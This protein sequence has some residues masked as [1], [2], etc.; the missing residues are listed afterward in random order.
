VSVN[1]NQ[2]PFSSDRPIA[3][4]EEDL[5]GRANF[6]EALATAIKS[7]REKDSLVIA[8]YG[9]WG[10]GKTS[11]KNMV[12]DYL[13]GS[14]KDS[15]EIVEFNPWQWAGQ[16]QL[17]NAFFEEIGKVLGR[18]TTRKTKQIAKK[19]K[20]YG[21]G[22]HLT[23]YV[24]TGFRNALSGLLL[25][26]AVFGIGGATVHSVLSNWLVSAI[27]Y[28]ALVLAI[29]TKWGGGF[30]EKLTAFLDARSTAQE[31]GSAELKRELAVSLQVLDRPVL[32]VVD[33]VDRL[34]GDEIR[35]L[36]QLIK[37][38][39][40]FP[41]L[42]YLVLFQR[43]IVQAA[44][45]RLS[46]APGQDFLEK[47][48]QVGLDIPRIERTRLEQVL[49]SGLDRIL[50]QQ[51][52]S[53]KFD[54]VRWANVFFPGLRPYFQT[55]RDVFRFL[56]T[57][58]FHV[59]IF[60]KSGPL[61]VNPIDLI[62]VETLRVFEPAVYS[63]LHDA[64]GMLTSTA[65]R[66]ED[67]RVRKGLQDI[68]A[69]APEQ[70]RSQVKELLS[71]LFPTVE[72]VFGGSRYGADWMEGWYRDLRICHEDIF[73]KYFYLAIPIGDISQ[74]DIERLLATTGNRA[75]LVTAFRALKE[76]G[77]LGV[78]IDR[79]EAYKQTISLD[80]A[81]PFVTALFDIGD[82]LPEGSPGLTNLSPEMH[83]SRIVYWY[84]K[85]EKDAAKR[86]TILK[87]AM[88]ATTGLY[89][90]IVRTSR[91]TRYPEKKREEG[92]FLVSEDAAKELQAICLQKIEAAASSGTLARHPELASILYR[93]RDWA[94]VEKPRAWIQTLIQSD[95]GVLAFLTAFLQQ[96][97][98]QTIGDHA[99][100]THWRIRLSSLEPFAEIE[101]LEHRVNS[102][103]VRQ[104][105]E[106]QSEAINQF[107]KAI[108]RKKQGRPDDDWFHDEHED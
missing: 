33:D 28:G 67:E 69:A 91:E 9:P 97:T 81:V 23:A 104:L 98:S 55:L 72:W 22:L 61:E 32:V 88:Q 68:M 12:L 71:E 38:N 18:R 76:Q 75:G 6:S 89:A 40:D 106:E 64:K 47:I 46:P 90:P 30:A 58:E 80:D 99:V 52:L 66:D 105:S 50:V 94:S 29:L 63:R 54:Q 51:G 13:R 87:A 19:W 42:V 3:T 37:A 93:W 82:D 95:E 10:S 57:F 4:R 43:D 8:L 34:S 77:L 36:F 107:R 85:Q 49:F 17:A 59:G 31:K 44:L 35:L 53:A 21:A 41:N 108:Q 96:S 92:A 27:G 16:E 78:A 86:A 45:D 84:L 5:L 73:D 101:Q 70:T 15:P 62:S 79:L 1:R 48:V 25:V 83:L 102:I 56:G 7:W 100:R 39:A 60:T 103:K 74:A 2:H 65:Q 11:V 14:V 24:A 20:L 26:I